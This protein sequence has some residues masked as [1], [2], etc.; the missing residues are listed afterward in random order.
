MEESAGW[1]S[2]L[3]Q[4]YADRTS[5]SESPAQVMAKRLQVMHGPE[6]VGE[7]EKAVARR[8]PSPESADLQAEDE[9]DETKQFAEYLGMSAEDDSHLL[10]I[11]EAAV[12]APLP[13]DWTQ[14]AI[15]PHH[16]AASRWP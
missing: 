7:E 2:L 3:R 10:W 12:R 11:A 13:S 8:P 1:Q 9:E 4:S 6:M 5:R 14:V 15:R 16:G